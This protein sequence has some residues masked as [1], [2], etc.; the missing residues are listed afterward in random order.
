MP[1]SGPVSSQHRTATS[2]QARPS[3]VGTCARGSPRKGAA[4]APGWRGR[5][6]GRGRGRLRLRLRPVSSSAQRPHPSTRQAAEEPQRETPLSRGGAAALR[7]RVAFSRESVTDTRL[8][9]SVRR[10]SGR[11]EAA[12]REHLAEPGELLRVVDRRGLGGRGLQEA[13]SPSRPQRQFSRQLS[14][15]RL[16]PRA[17]R[18]PRF[19]SSPSVEGSSRVTLEGPARH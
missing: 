4:G 18:A 15:R 13:L 19:P 11:G 5:G 1:P 10:A 17:L 8:S 16:P 12:G 3:D 14:S 7:R 9:L 6:R 2:R